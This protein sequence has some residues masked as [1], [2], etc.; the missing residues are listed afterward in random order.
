MSEERA[1]IPGQL[2]VDEL[3]QLAHVY[4]AY[5][6]GGYGGGA[7]YGGGGYGGELEEEPAE[8]EEA[9]DAPE[10]EEGA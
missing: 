10:E 7:G 3:E 9:G 1:H 5:G 6:G 4:S 2:S 8:E